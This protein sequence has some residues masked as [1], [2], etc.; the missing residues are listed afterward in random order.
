MPVTP[1]RRYLREGGAVPF[2]KPVRGSAFDGLDD[3]LRERF[4]RHDGSADVVRQELPSEQG[5]VIGLRSVE[6]AQKRATVRFETPPGRRLRAAGS[7]VG[8]C[9]RRIWTGG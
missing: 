9:S 6:K 5:I 2:K 8:R 4:F 1:V 7:R 3:W